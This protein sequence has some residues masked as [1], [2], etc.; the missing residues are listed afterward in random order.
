MKDQLTGLFNRH[1]MMESG[2]KAIKQAQRHKYPLS[3]L[4]LD[5]DNFKSINDQHGHATRDTVLESVGTTLLNSFREEDI[6]CRFGGEEFVVI[7]PNCNLSEAAIKAEQL[8]LI[9]ENGHPAG[10]LVTASIGV[11]SLFI[12]DNTDTFATLFSRADHG[13]Y[14]AK[15]NGRNQVV[16][17]DK[18]PDSRT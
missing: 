16:L 15:A 12:D 11:G 17:T 14:Q 1:F 8:R 10:L 9:I 13:T 3:M 7:L 5:L 18:N 6:A 2:P 4:V